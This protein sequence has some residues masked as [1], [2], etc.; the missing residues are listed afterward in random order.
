[1]ICFS[2]AAGVHGS[3]SHIDSA[4]D[5][6]FD[7]HALRA[8]L[9]AESHDAGRSCTG[10]RILVDDATVTIENIHRHMAMGKGIK[11]AILDGSQQ[12]VV[13]ALVSMLCICIVFYPCCCSP[14]RRNTCLR[15]WRWPLC[16]Q[17]WHRMDCRA[18]WCRSWRAICCWRTSM[19]TAGA[20]WLAAY[21]GRDQ[22]RAFAQP[23]PDQYC[24]GLWSAGSQCSHCSSSL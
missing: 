18:R 2:S 15:Q 16:F 14:A 8:G 6:V 11:Q 3:G 22:L 23:V 4:G 10:G 5:P 13:P 17:F 1:L 19:E 9:F 21:F 7:H 20:R 12:I 24:A